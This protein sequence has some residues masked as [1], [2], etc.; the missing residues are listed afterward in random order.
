MGT[1]RTKE[2]LLEKSSSDTTPRCH[3][4]VITTGPHGVELG[5]RHMR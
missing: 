1:G 5:E 4:R 2:L 3:H